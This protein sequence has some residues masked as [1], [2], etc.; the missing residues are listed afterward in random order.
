MYTTPS[1]EAYIYEILL[2][3]V[4][5]SIFVV[6]ARGCGLGATLPAA[7]NDELSSA[8]GTPAYWEAA[9]RT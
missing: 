8:D 1:F 4:P 5:R 6:Q 9:R 7:E 2:M 3:I